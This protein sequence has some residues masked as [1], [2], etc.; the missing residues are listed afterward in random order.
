M[1]AGGTTPASFDWCLSLTSY[2][3][4]SIN[5]CCVCFIFL[6]P[7]SVVILVRVQGGTK[8]RAV[9]SLNQVCDNLLRV[10]F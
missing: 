10:M 9:H 4:N 8:N 3:M 6:L 5:K 1:R 7:R 2:T